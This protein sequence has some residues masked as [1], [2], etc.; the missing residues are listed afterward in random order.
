MLPN[1]DIRDLIRK[2]RIKQYEIADEM[3]MAESG[4]SKLLRKEL[5]EELKSEIRA[6]IDRLAE[7]AV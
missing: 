7:R 6:I 1:E 4:F 3:K 2:K 5:S